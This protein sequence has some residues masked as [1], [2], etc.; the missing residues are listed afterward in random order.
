[1]YNPTAITPVYT[2]IPFVTDPQSVSS[3][4]VS[5]HVINAVK[6]TQK[7]TNA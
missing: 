5:L 7:T 2:I 6:H 1:M 4:S 3:I